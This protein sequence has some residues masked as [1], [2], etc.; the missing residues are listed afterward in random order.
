MSVTFRAVVAAVAVLAAC[1]GED[2]GIEAV[3]AGDTTAAD[4][5]A[6]DTRLPPLDVTPM[7][8]A[9]TA[10]A[11]DTGATGDTAADD[12]GGC[13]GGFECPCNGNSDC[14][15]ELCVEGRDGRIC[16][17][18][19]VAECPG[20][21]DCVSSTAMG[22]DPIF[23]C[24]P[25]HARLCR[26]CRADADCQDAGDPFPAYCLPAPDA[27]QGSFCGSSCAGRECPEGYGCESVTLPSGGVAKQCAPAGG[28]QCQCR[29]SWDGLGF[30]TTC[31]ITNGYGTCD[32]TRT[33]GAFGLTPCDGPQASQEICDDVDNDCDGETDNIAASP[34][35]LQN[36]YGTCPGTLACG[37]LGPE[38][39]GT[40]P[41]AE[42]CNGA[43]DNCNS[44][45]D[46][47]GCDDG[48]GCTTDTCAGPFD[49]RHQLQ[50]GFCAIDAACWGNG[51]FNPNNACQV[52]NSGTSTSA[53]SQAPNTCLINGQC[54]PNGAVNP[55]NACQVCDVTQGASAWSVAGNTCTIGGTCYASGAANPQ[56]ACEICAPSQST[57]AWTQAVAT[58]NIQGQCYASGVTKPGAPCLV[59]SP[60]QNATGWTARPSTASCDDGSACSS[61]DHCDG[62]G[63]CIGDKSCNDGVACTTDS[64]TP[65]GCDN[66]GV[67][68]GWCRIGGTCYTNNT[69]NPGNVCQRC[70]PGASKTAWSPQPST[71]ACEDGSA[72]TTGDHCNGSGSCTSGGACY[73]GLSCTN[74]ICNPSVGCSYPT[75]SGKCKINDA[76]YSN[77]DTQPGN[78]CYKCNTSTTQSGWSYN[79]GASCNDGNSC[80][81]GDTCASGTCAGTANTDGYE[82][83]NSVGAA[84]SLPYNFGD[85]D[86]WPDDARSTTANLYPSGDEDWFKYRVSDNTNVYQPHPT[87]ELSAI[88]AGMNYNLC[89]YWQCDDPGDGQSASCEQGSSTATVNGMPGCCSAASGSSTEIVELKPDCPNGG[90]FSADDETGTAFVR[91]YRVSGTWTCSNYSLK[92]GNN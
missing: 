80:T 62:A 92:Y 21:Y 28:G 14:V 91:V 72:C 22:P 31:G 23:L 20:G 29:P 69:S 58:C 51:A 70:N 71:V 24:L 63:L 37:S 13:G 54:Y 2:G 3:D 50:V 40:A 52:C 90:T 79:N 47:A 74:D 60:D 76:C 25:R 8:T 43:D 64:C 15:D 66:S 45:T 34:C 82:G 35:S 32:G 55:N 5:V 59:C 10:S 65:S 77:G 17:R 73:D 27:A 26:P 57:T 89:V 84:K 86:G 46:E 12:T 30:A 36:Q 81:S 53:W 67:P 38:C 41:V 33:C 19:C 61:D 88:P 39:Q 75:A 16:T 1:G 85:G 49:C 42:A 87:V 56:N 9:D 78:V 18:T 6:I 48:L 83:N 11:G 44:Q 4:T 68:T 7:D